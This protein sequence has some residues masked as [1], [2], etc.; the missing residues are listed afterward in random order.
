MA[1]EMRGSL[2]L[3]QFYTKPNQPKFYGRALINGKTYE[4]K[5]WEK[6]GP[7]GPWIS[8]M[9]E[10]PENKGEREFLSGQEQTKSAEKQTVTDWIDDDIPF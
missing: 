4:I 10:D 9:F 6:D 8:L 2:N 3:S 7:R 5:G 1:M